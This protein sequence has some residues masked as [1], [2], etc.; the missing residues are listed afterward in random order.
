MSDKSIYRHP[1]THWQ[2]LAD[3]IF[4]YPD[5]AQNAVFEIG[6][7]E[8]NQYGS[9]F[10]LQ[11]DTFQ[12]V[13]MERAT[14]S[15]ILAETLKVDRGGSPPS[16]ITARGDIPKPTGTRREIRYQIDWP[17]SGVALAQL[18]AIGVPSQ[19]LYEFAEDC[20]VLIS[21][22]YIRHHGASR[23][24]WGRIGQITSDFEEVPYDVISGARILNRRT[25]EIICHD[26]TMIFSVSVSPLALL[27]D[28]DATRRQIIYYAADLL[29]SNI[30]TKKVILDKLI[31]KYPDFQFSHRDFNQNIW[32]KA[33]EKAGL[34]I[35]GRPG[36]PSKNQNGN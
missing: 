1:Q 31:Q 19:R 13:Q 14:R 9:Q 6:M 23:Q 32:G 33:R 7:G 12:F 15:L 21:L 25:G 30:Q 26:G 34:S 24:F 8:E 10:L 16:K 27:N 20:L 4:D 28:E 22:L 35:K 36:R 11:F 5:A 29:K 3:I 2:P 17:N 18:H